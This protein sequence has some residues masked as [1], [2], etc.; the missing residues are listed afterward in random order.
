MKIVGNNVNESVQLWMR[1]QV[2]FDFL[3][4]LFLFGSSF[5][6]FWQNNFFG[7]Y[8]F[9]LFN[10]IHLLVVYQN[11]KEN[12]LVIKNFYRHFWGVSILFIVI[13]MV[14]YVNNFS[15]IT[16]FLSANLFFMFGFIY[17]QRILDILKR[18]L[19]DDVSDNNLI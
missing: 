17:K 3:N 7:S 9:N 19:I 13:N 18:K 14:V 1:Q 11:L 2:V 15:Q 6:Q 10:A 4:L 8:A 5:F 12:S 16:L